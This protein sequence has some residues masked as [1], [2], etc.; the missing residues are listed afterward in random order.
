MAPNQQHRLKQHGSLQQREW[1]I[2]RIG[3]VIWG[4][5]ILAGLAGLLG[6]GPL[7]STSAVSVDGTVEVRFDRYEHSHDPI[8]LELLL[9]PT[10]QYE[11]L[12]VAF[13]RSFLDHVRIHR[14]EPEPER[15]LLQKDSVVYSFPLGSIAGAVKVQM[16]LE[17][18]KF[19]DV[20]GE[21]GLVDHSPVRIR[22]FVYP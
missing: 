6:T 4:L 10:A 9:S 5:I 1:K 12:Q 3:W 17:Y 13:S 15:C 11:D 22:Q 7:S 18:R 19:G 16:H 8:T 20:D 2:Q 21:I 14:M